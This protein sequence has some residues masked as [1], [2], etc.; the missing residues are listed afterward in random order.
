[1]ELVV[2]EVH[3]SATTGKYFDN[4]L[5]FLV[6]SRRIRDISKG[7]SRHSRPAVDGRSNMCGHTSKVGTYLSNLF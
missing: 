3:H 7:V 6:L 2:E 5:L 4:E 1:M